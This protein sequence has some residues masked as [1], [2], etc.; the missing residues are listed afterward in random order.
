MRVRVSEDGEVRV[1][2][3]S[4]VKGGRGRYEDRIYREREKRNNAAG[5]AGADAA[6][7]LE[8]EREPNPPNADPPSL[9]FFFFLLS[10]VLI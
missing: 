6:D 3:F 9:F 10:L 4:V 7:V 1:S 2:C 5:Y 8:K